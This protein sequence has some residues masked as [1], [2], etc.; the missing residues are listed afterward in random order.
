MKQRTELEREL[1]G[2]RAPDE[3]R[4][5]E[6]GLRVVRGS[7][8]PDA[9]PAARSRLRP[10]AA[11]AVIA[12]ALLAGLVLTPAGASVRDWLAGAIDSDA[13]SPVLD[14]LP[15]GGQLLSSSRRGSWVIAEDGS[16]RRLGAYQQ[17]TWSPSG[18]FVAAT[19]DQLLTAVEPDG[20]ERWSLGA[21]APVSDPVWA[22]PSG[23]RIAYRSGRALRVVNG[24]GT[25]DRELIDDVTPTA[26]AWMPGNPDLTPPFVVAFADP[27][28]RVRAIDVDNPKEPLSAPAWVRAE[29][30]LWPTP[31]RLLAISDSEVVVLGP[32]LRPL[33]RIPLPEATQVDDAA[34]S[35]SGRR[36]VI[37][38]AGSTLGRSELLLGRVAGSRSRVRRVF[39]VPGRYGGLAFSGDGRWI[40][41]GWPEA[42][43]WLFIRPRP[44][45]KSLDR[46]EAF[47]GISRQLDPGGGPRTPFPEIEGWCC[48]GPGA[49]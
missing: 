30:L 11:L 8:Q 49:G 32:T 3:V 4:A 12:A 21:E 31:G 13:E 7:L 42:D 48:A 9:R 41:A 20:E 27:D 38:A 34:V 46:I 6:R 19:R 40:A 18:L 35:P 5:A 23:F 16:R 24:D 39:E 22:E 2:Y 14:R 47:D 25:G 26:P 1:A 10:R 29:R 17:A 28:G 15:T 37:A 45:R 33:R 36:F 44:N 43:S